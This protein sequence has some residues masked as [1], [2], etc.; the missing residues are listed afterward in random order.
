MEIKKTLMISALVGLS[1]TLALAQ[2]MAPGENVVGKVT[3]VNGTTL[4]VAPLAGGDPVTVKIGGNARVIKDRQPAA[5]ADIKVDDMVFARGSMSGKSLD[6]VLVTLINPE[7]VQRMQQGGMGQ[8]NRDDLGKKII[9]GEVKAINEL[10]LTIARPDN[11]TQEIE[12]DENT[13]FRKGRESI[14]LAD[15]KVGD[16]VRGTGDLKEGVFIPKELNVGRPGMVMGFGGAGGRGQGGMVNPSDLGKTFIAG[17][18]KAVALQQN[19]ITVSRIDQQTQDILVD[20][21]TSLKH[22]P[23]NTSI[24]LA[25]V[26]IGDIVRG[27][28]EVKDGV[29]VPRE[30]TFSRSRNAGEADAEKPPSSVAPKN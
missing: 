8:F 30:L 19:T 15:I 12:V 29:F 18:V 24:T 4:T 23:E 10:K 13:S 9:L 22:I 1:V 26:K 25:D 14:T 3:A 6:A 5:A 21:I 2:G 16:F 20:K 27:P 11:Q 28:G 17:R 7:M